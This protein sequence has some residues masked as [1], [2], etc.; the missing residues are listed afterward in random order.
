[1]TFFVKIVDWLDHF[2]LNSSSDSLRNLLSFLLWEVGVDF[3]IT[4]FG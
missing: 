4:V 1:M 3:E 2:Y